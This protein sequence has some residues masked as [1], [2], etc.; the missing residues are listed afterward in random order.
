MKTKLTIT[1][2]GTEHELS[3]ADVFNWDEVL[4]TYKRT[5][6]SGVVR[7]FSSKF[8]FVNDAYELLL[9]AYLQ[10][11]VRASA[12]VTLYTLNNDWTWKKEF[13]SA[14]NFS[15]AT[16]DGYIFSVNCIDNRLASL[17]KANKSTKYEFAVGSDIPT[18]KSL[19]FDRI[20]MNEALSFQIIGESND[21]DSSMVVTK[22]AW[23]VHRVYVGST[24]EEVAVN[25]ALEE[26]HDQTED[27]GGYILK[28]K[29]DVQLKVVSGFA[30]DLLTNYTDLTTISFRLYKTSTEGVDTELC[31]LGTNPNVYFGE[32]NS[33]S[34]LTTEFTGFNYG[35]TALLKTTNTI[36]K[37]MEAPDK[38]DNEVKWR[39][40]GLPL[41]EYMMQLTYQESIVD[42]QA[43]DKVWIGFKGQPWNWNYQG[44]LH[45][46]ILKQDIKISWAGK[47]ESET[48]ETISPK[49]LCDKL[50]EKIAG[51]SI[52]VN[53]K[54]SD[55]DSRFASTYILA[56]ESIRAIPTAKIYSSFNEFTD[57]MQT[58]FGYTYYIGDITPA[59]YSGSHQFFTE[60]P[61]GDMELTNDVCPSQYVKVN[62]L[63]YLHEQMIFAVLHDRDFK[64]CT[65]W[66][67]CDACPSD[68][69]YN[70]PVTGK[71][72][73]DKVYVDVNGEAYYIDAN[74][75][76]Q[77]YS[78]DPATCACDSQDV[79]FVHLTELFNADSPIYQ[80]ESCREINYKIDT[81]LIYSAVT[82]GYEK[83]DYEGVNG[84]DEFNFNNSY[85]TGCTVIE[86]TLSLISKYRAD[87][88]G[89]EFTLQKRGED[90]TDNS[91][92][93]DVFFVL[94]EE[95]GEY[96]VPSKKVK[97]QN[98]VSDSVFNGEFCPMECI[99]ANAGYIGIQEKK[100]TLTFASS[101][102][103]SDVIVGGVPMS[104]DISIDEPIATCGVLSFESDDTE[105]ENNV[106]NI[107]RVES[108]GL[109]YSGFLKETEFC[110]SRPSEVKYTLIVKDI[111]PI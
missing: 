49:V 11:G 46:K 65:K 89:I 42:I 72:R 55:F 2:D 77:K 95:S 35:C 102:G 60:W 84:R 1:I 82:I 105:V 29:I 101:T 23:N 75:K 52:R 85:S 13:E 6:F 36:W 71:A 27:A 8:E 62:Q 17:I 40:T 32:V 67:A 61:L 97:I 110:Y 87:C 45:I 33:I 108:R 37:I 3:S 91:S 59:E 34:E 69:A 66:E 64:F 81:G 99:K 7:S 58:V 103:N 111:Q 56:A 57:W 74:Y 38:S 90:T 63:V 88:Y 41:N 73:L 54:F 83:Q 68:S 25:G 12:I 70:D 43:G 39:D 79:V 96:V 100:V 76:M 4:C 47:G 92:D 14:L 50:L 106:N 20:P 24:N 5:D 31:I 18:D 98:T 10:N 21:Q 30:F 53:S 15:T 48:I 28:A 19:F 109:L 86:K 104:S 26:W 78:G 51:S 22:P 94:C 80:V 107:I 93:K 16:W 44:N 9:T